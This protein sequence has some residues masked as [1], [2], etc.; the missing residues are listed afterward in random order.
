MTNTPKPLKKLHKAAPDLLASLKEA[1]P[2]LRGHQEDERKRD[3]YSRAAAAI[4][5]AEG[6]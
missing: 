5:K 6:C 3:R 4:A 2:L 1:M